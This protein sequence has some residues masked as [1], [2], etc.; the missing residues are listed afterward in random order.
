MTTRSQ[1]QLEGVHPLK[2]NLRYVI[3]TIYHF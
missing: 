1:L 3:V 2:K